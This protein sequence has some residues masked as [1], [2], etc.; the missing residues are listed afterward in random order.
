MLILQWRWDFNLAEVEESSYGAFAPYKDIIPI[1]SGSQ[2]PRF[3]S[4]S[5]KTF[6]LHSPPTGLHLSKNKVTKLHAWA[7]RVFMQTIVTVNNY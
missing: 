3:T 6:W 1:L 5:R 7:V 4:A 2:V